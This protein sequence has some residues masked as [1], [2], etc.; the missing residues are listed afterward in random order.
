VKAP[1]KFLIPVFLLLVVTVV[2][3]FARTAIAQASD[4]YVSSLQ[5]VDARSSLRAFDLPDKS[6]LF[7]KSKRTSSEE[8]SASLGFDLSVD[9]FSFVNW[10][11]RGGEHAFDQSAMVEIFGAYQ[12]CKSAVPVGC[13]LTNA[14]EEMRD[15]LEEGLAEGHCEGMVVA[16]ALNYLGRINGTGSV[17]G[18]SRNESKTAISKWWATQ[19]DPDVRLASTRTRI[20]MPSELARTIFERIVDREPVTMGVYADGFAHSVLP[21]SATWFGSV[22]AVGVYDPNSPDQERYVM[23]DTATESWT[24]ET[25]VHRVGVLETVSGLG[26]GGLDLVPIETRSLPVSTSIG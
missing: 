17:A 26:S 6:E 18:G 16:A 2:A 12:V 24:Y 25:Y 5:K 20:L 22:L 3:L 9:A 10:A 14:A 19:F 8:V 11:N 4:S 13:E 1:N 21:I 7:R 15:R 23:I